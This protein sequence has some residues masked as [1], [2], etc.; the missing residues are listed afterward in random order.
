MET[1]AGT[2]CSLFLAQSLQ[3][4][5][6]K[7]FISGATQW[8]SDIATRSV[9][10]ISSCH[11]LLTAVLYTHNFLTVYLGTILPVSF[12]HVSLMYWSLSSLWVLVACM[13]DD[14]SGYHG[15][16]VSYT[17]RWRCIWEFKHRGQ[18]PRSLNPMILL[19]ITV[20]ESPCDV[21]AYH[22]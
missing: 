7:S 22:A 16:N 20:Q 19:E 2:V 8:E 15:I 13:A 18:S 11:V 1:V 3:S 6:Q 12:I 14:D 4:I 10:H 9:L 17:P 5:S 21:M